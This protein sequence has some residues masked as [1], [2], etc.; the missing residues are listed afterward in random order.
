MFIQRPRSFNIQTWKPEVVV[1]TGLYWGW[2]GLV[3][4]L[5]FFPFFFTKWIVVPLVLGWIVVLGY[6][7]RLQITRQSIEVRTTFMGFGLLREVYAMD[8]AWV[9]YGFDMDRLLPP[10][11]EIGSLSIGDET[12]AIPLLN[13]IKAAI[14]HV[15]GKTEVELAHCR[16]ASPVRDAPRKTPVPALEAVA[17]IKRFQEL[18]LEVLMVR[19]WK[20][21]DAQRVTLYVVSEACIRVFDAYIRTEDIHE[22]ETFGPTTAHDDEMAFTT[23]RRFVWTEAPFR[24]WQRGTKVAQLYPGSIWTA[25]R[26]IKRADIVSVRGWLSENWAK[27]GVDLETTS[28]ERVDVAV[29]HNPDSYLNPFYDGIDLMFDVEWVESIS[30]ILARELDVPCVDDNL[31]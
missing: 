20:L 6:R 5:M 25:K 30:R 1:I 12:N 13:T 16:L 15:Q 24:L 4:P 26:E 21:D 9:Q 10:D 8:E 7:F 27:L 18:G 31:R 23:R 11:V 2:T 3:F 19:G 14:A 22:L 29:G 17:V 28:G